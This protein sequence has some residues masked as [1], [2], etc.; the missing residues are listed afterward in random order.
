MK[1]IEDFLFEHKMTFLIQEKFQRLI[2]L[3]KRYE[4]DAQFRK[5]RVRL[6]ELSD[7]HHFSSSVLKGEAWSDAASATLNN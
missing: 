3:I 7:H 2:L 4:P 5:Y 1:I 6:Q